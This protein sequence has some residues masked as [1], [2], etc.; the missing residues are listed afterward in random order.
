MKYKLYHIPGKKIGITKDVK[1]RIEQQQGYTLGEYEILEESD[2]IDYISTRE[3]D[4]QEMFGYRIDET[5]YNQLNQNKMRVNVTEQTTTF[6]CPVNKLK[7]RLMDSIGMK[8]TTNHGKHE[9]TPGLVR[10]IENNVVTSQFN[11]DRCYVYNKA[12][13]NYK[14][15]DW[16]ESVENVDKQ[17]SHSGVFQNIRMWAEERGIYDKGDSST[18]YIKLMEEAGELAQALLKRDEP[19]IMD[20]IGDMVVVLTNLAHME[21]L[22][23]E[24]CVEAAYTEIKNRQGK[25][26]NGTFV[27]SL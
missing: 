4:L 19:E 9:L 17:I 14:D 20:A 25:M 23:I 10:W 15:I 16:R 11:E 5:P 27:K 8:I 6:P 22:E 13:S 21:G 26:V 7:G 24:D 2:D 18:Q 12:M 1:R 3:L